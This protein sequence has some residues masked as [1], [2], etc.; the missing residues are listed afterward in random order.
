[1]KQK[2]MKSLLKNKRGAISGL[3]SGAGDV[4]KAAF[5]TIPKPI[6]FLFF[7]L[8][9]LF[10]GSLIHYS[11]SFFGIFCDSVDN[12]VN[13]GFNIIQNIN[14]LDDIP[15]DNPNLVDLSS[16]LFVSGKKATDCSI[17]L[18]SGEIFYEEENI[19]ESITSPEWFYDGTFCTEC[20]EVEIYDWTPQSILVDIRPDTGICRG[21]VYRV[22]NKGWWKKFWC[23]TLKIEYCQ[24]P[25]HFYYDSSSNKYVCK[26]GDDCGIL[27]EQDSAQFWDERLNEVGAIY[28]Y[29]EGYIT[30]TSYEKLVGVACTDF[31]PNITVYGIPIFD[32]KIWIMLM[33]AGILVWVLINIK[34]K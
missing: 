29:P 8:I 26:S 28:L 18:T 11:L 21:D 17:R 7:L 20:E 12:P 5:D 23:D 24:P 16:V 15:Q 9:L 33:L 25:Q 13:V 19:T 27:V 10:I 32:Y 6:K 1:M 14:L 31:K 30:R 2:I 3:F 4:I 22:E 34:K